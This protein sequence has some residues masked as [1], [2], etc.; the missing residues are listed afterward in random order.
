VWV[1][2]LRTLAPNHL[3]QFTV[4]SLQWELWPEPWLDSIYPLCEIRFWKGKKLPFFLFAFMGGGCVWSSNW[5][6]MYGIASELLRKWKDKQIFGF[7]MFWAKNVSFRCGLPNLC[8]NDCTV[9]HFVFSWILP[10][11]P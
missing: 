3:P 8:T 9:F 7:C 1:I 6:W 2:E 5:L 4:W 11:Q 10:F